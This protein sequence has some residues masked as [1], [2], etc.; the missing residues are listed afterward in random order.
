MF[1]IGS[2]QLED[3]EVKILEITSRNTYPILTDYCYYKDDDHVFATQYEELPGR[4]S[5]IMLLPE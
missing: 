5:S 2:S 4:E 3:L 1:Q